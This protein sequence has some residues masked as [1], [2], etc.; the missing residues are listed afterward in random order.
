MDFLLNL[1]TFS[2]WTEGN[3]CKMLRVVAYVELVSFN[4]RLTL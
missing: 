2:K 1:L 4:I 3:S